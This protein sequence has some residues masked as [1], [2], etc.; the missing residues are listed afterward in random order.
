MTC[1]E[2]LRKHQDDSFIDE[3]DEYFVNKKKEIK[4]HGNEKVNRQLF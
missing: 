2:W 3:L 4:K 1:Y